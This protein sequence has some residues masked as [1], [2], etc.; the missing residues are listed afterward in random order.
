VH[1]PTLPIARTERAQRPDAASLFAGRYDVQSRLGIGGMAEVMLARD[2]VLGRLV[3]LKLLAPALAADPVFVERFRREATAVASLNHPN[4]VVVF[5]H[6]V[7]DGQP[8]IAMEYVP[9]RT[10]KQVIAESA[11]MPPEVAAGYARQTLA[12]LSA[13]HAVGIVHR[14]VK[15]QNLIVRADG[16]LKVADFGVARSAEQTVLTQHGSVIGTAEYLSPEQARGETAMAASDLY[17]VGVVLFEM[18]T[19]RPPFAG[20][21]ALAIANQHIVETAPPVREVNRAVPAD[22]ARIVD[23]ALAKDPGDRFAS[24]TAMMAAL[25]DATSSEPSATLLAP[26]AVMT[27]DD[28]NAPTRV[29]AARA[30]PPRPRTGVHL[31]R[32]AFAALAALLVLTAGAFALLTSGGGGSRRVPMP[33]VV[34]SPVERATSTLRGLGFEVRVGKGQP[35]A[36]PSGTVAR[37]RPATTTA[38]SGALITLIPSTGPRQVAIPPV[39]GLTMQ[40]AVAALQRSGFVVHVATAYATAPAGIAVAT[41]PATGATTPP[42]SSIVLTVSAGPAPIP[43]ADQP[44]GPGNGKGPGSKGAGH[45]KIK[46]DK[47]AKGK[48]GD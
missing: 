12:G 43:P 17:S 18:L 36:L 40:D 10:L 1:K 20:E 44:P 31:R 32:R 15:P 13:A 34:G 41:T 9:G 47:R 46:G 35:A 3:A 26:T 28:R 37:T 6:G 39:A 4:V 11:P 16:T 27:G 24:A 19:G 14:D 38:A 21:A 30:Q 22:I 8:F 29:Q 45:H 5:D 42:R 48:G 2:Q 25:A 23:R 33:H 7:A